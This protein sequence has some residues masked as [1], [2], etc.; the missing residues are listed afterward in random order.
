VKSKRP[1]LA[2]PIVTINAA[3][4]AVGT[5]DAGVIVHVPGLPVP[6]ER[7]TLWLYPLTAVKVPFHVIVCAASTVAGVAIT[8]TAKSGTG[9]ITASVRVRV[10]GAGAPALVA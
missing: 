10:L 7:F 6:H 2:L 9:A 5:S 3:P 1:V 4:L 8:A